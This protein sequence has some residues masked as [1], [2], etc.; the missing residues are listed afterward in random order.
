MLTIAGTPAQASI[1]STA[2]SPSPQAPCGY[3]PEGTQAYYQHC[4]SRTRVVIRVEMVFADDYDRCVGPGITHL[5]PK[6][7]S[8]ITPGVTGAYYVGRTC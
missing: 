1:S 7:L 6:S 3:Y 8:G 5:G 2:A 4:D